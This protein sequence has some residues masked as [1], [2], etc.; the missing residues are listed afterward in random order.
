MFRVG[1]RESLGDIFDQI[2]NEMR[3]QYA[4]AYSPTN[5]EKDGRFRK[6]EIKTTRKDL[7]VQ[8]RKG[9]YATASVR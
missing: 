5:A 8:A 1:R 9:Y 4:L 7:R 6:L 2:Q 3:S